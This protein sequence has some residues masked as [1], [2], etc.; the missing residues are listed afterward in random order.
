VQA[1]STRKAQEF[2]HGEHEDTERLNIISPL[3]SG[4]NLIV[5]ACDFKEN[6]H[7]IKVIWASDALTLESRS[8]MDKASDF[9]SDGCAIPNVR[10]SGGSIRWSRLKAG[11]STAGRTRRGRFIYGGN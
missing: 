6:I 5:D 4:E 9:G 3:R 1:L 7:F 11:D 2:N 8:S 10:C